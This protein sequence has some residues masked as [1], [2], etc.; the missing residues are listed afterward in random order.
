[1]IRI[2]LGDFDDGNSLNIEDE[3]VTFR[4][5]LRSAFSSEIENQRLDCF[6]SPSQA[7]N[8]HFRVFKRSAKGGTLS[9][10]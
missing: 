5:S 6:L 2:L 4:K 1:M 9:T 7:K 10:S 3:S 8:S